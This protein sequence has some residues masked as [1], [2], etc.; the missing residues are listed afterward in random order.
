MA[1]RTET[2]KRDE[3]S[4]RAK[5]RAKEKQIS[6]RDAL[7]E[8]AGEDPQLTEEARLEV[9]GMRVEIV[10]VDPSLRDRL[11]INKIG[12]HS[13]GYTYVVDVSERL[14]DL[15]HARATEKISRITPHFPKLVRKFL[16]LLSWPGSRGLAT[17][18]EEGV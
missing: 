3:L 16:R 2:R 13:T 9:L 18:F 10:P 15:A 4:A 7:S 17:R 12:P 5:A 1:W 6:L 11:R 14:A 8:I